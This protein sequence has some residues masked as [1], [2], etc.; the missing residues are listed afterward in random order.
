MASSVVTW[1]K[2][3]AGKESGEG[4][5]KKRERTDYFRGRESEENTRGAEEREDTLRGKDMG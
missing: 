3:K 2:R 1:E 5:V 4:R